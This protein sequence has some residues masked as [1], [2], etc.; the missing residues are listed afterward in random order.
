LLVGTDQGCSTCQES[1]MFLLSRVLLPSFVTQ[2][3]LQDGIAE[4]EMEDESVSAAMTFEFSLDL[5]DVLLSCLLKLQT[6]LG[7]CVATNF[8]GL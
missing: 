7:D 4:V 3:W 5:Q 2:V 8:K 6:C 1:P